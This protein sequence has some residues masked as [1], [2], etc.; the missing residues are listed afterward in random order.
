M[1][2]NN[3]QEKGTD[4]NENILELNENDDNLKKLNEQNFGELTQ[5][6]FE[7]MRKIR[8]ET[9]SRTERYSELISE[10]NSQDIFIKIPNNK[11]KKSNSI[12]KNINDND[13]I[14]TS[15]T[16]GI[17][18]N[19]QKEEINPNK[20]RIFKLSQPILFIKEE[21]LIILGPNTI[22]FIF[23]FSFVS[24]LS[25]IIYSFKNQNIFLKILFIF[26]YL[27]FSI[28]YIL[29]LLINPGIPK[30]KNKIDPSNLQSYYFQC[31]DCNCIS[32][33][34]KEKRAYHCQ[35]CKICIEDFSH[36]SHLATKCIGKGNKQ[37]YKIW[38]YS[39]GIFFAIAF[40]YLII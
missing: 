10:P 39:I 13:S 20:E 1:K 35:I 19:I 25:I 9:I 12:K 32:L 14:Q 17:T 34:Q 33:K 18:D 6:Q 8:E 23:I 2:D 15:N 11:N 5:E 30:N 16:I 4:S 37:L 7:L 31:K 38:L 28:T 26:G 40:F 24:F 27:F 3:D 21:P 36:H 22:Y 29:L